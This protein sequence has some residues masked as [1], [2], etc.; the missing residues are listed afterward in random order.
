[1]KF[2][3]L[4]AALVAF[5]SAAANGQA[6]CPV[7]DITG[8]AGLTAN[9]EIATLAA[10]TNPVVQDAK[11]GW[12]VTAGTIDKGQ[13]TSVVEIRTPLLPPT[14]TLTVQVKAT[15]LP[16]GCPDT[17]SETIGVGGK[18]G[19]ATLDDYADISADEEARRLDVVAFQAGQK[20]GS[21]IV[22]V[23]SKAKKEREATLDT[24]IARVRKHLTS[25]SIPADRMV[26]LKT[27]HEV[28]STKLYLI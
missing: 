19:V 16:D 15:G 20:P 7:L 26:F 27:T 11:F 28:R 2:L 14:G 22:V 4:S 3:F 1:M 6:A 23:V 18:P 24:R 5:C 13:E 17:S 12:T 25:R 8:P 10:S 9:G 21:T